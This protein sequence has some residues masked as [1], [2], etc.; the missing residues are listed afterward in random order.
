MN[1]HLGGRADTYPKRRGL[2]RV[3]ELTEAGCN[4]SFGT[5][6]ILILGIQWEVE[7]CV[8]LCIWESILDI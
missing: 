4:V 5:D 8:T 2:T 7:I 3:K 1:V 6:D